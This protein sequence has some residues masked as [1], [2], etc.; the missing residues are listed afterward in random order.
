MQDPQADH[1]VP[2][3]A[4]TLSPETN[5]GT[6]LRR[7]ATAIAEFEG[8]CAP[9]RARAVVHHGVVFRT[10]S[11]GNVGYVGSAIR[12]AQSTLKRA[13]ATVG[14]AA[15][16]EFSG[17]A[18]KMDRVIR[19]G[20]ISGSNVDRLSSIGFVEAL[21]P[22]PGKSSGRLSATDPEL[23][24]FLKKRLAVDV[25]PFASVL[26]DTALHSASTASQLVAELSREVDDAAARRRFESDVR[27]YVKSRFKT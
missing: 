7:L 18:S 9:L 14:L 27:A 20:P 13:P 24:Q 3:L 12:S 16:H 17:F 2:H 22:T 4:L 26:V 11:G 8:L 23:L 21:D 5:V 15:T 10:E 19:L 6:A 25:G 1:G